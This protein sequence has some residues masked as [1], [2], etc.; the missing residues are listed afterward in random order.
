MSTE[1]RENLDAIL[2]QSAFPAGIS[3]SEQR[4]LL[5]ELTAA[6][7]LPADVSVTAGALGGVPTA[8]ITIAGIEPRHA[9]LYFHGGVYV[10]G[11]A[12]AAADLAAQI[13]RRTGARVLSVDYRLAPE[14]RYPAALHD[15]VAAVRYISAHA[16]AFGMD[17]AKLGVCGDSAG[18][19]LAT[20]ACQA[21]A[22]AGGPSLAL[23]LLICPILD[24]GGSTP[25]KREFSSGYLVDQATLDHDLMHYLPAGVDPATP[26][27]SPLR[28]EDLAGMP[29]TLIHTAEFDPL[30]DEGRNYFERL[31]QARNEVSYTCHPGMIHLFYGLGAVIPYARTAF[32][33]IGGEIR[34][35]LAN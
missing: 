12:F 17:G 4:R 23:Q 27:I 11:D 2:R 30:R 25:S 21:A 13:G 34:A 6:Q 3:V 7:P 14:H 29:P 15:A 22:R 9:V 31:T 35:A 5:R 24:Y 33:Q 28:A 8:E 26:D 10:L 32:E 1:Q 20:A 19:T 16:E 18:A